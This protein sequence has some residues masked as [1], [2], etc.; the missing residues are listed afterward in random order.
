M[1]LGV[2]PHIFL[3]RLLLAFAVVYFL[4][5]P[6]APGYT[7]VLAGITRVALNASEALSGQSGRT[8]MYVREAADGKPAI[9]YQHGRFPQLESGI[10]A[11]WV[12]ANIVLLIPLMLAVP[13]ATYGQRGKRLALAILL[14]IL[15]QV[16]D[17]MVTVKAFY[18]SYPPTGYG[19]LTR[20]FYQFGDAFAQAFDT[21]LFPFVIW[22][23]I[24]FRQL[25]GQQQT[26]SSLPAAKPSPRPPR[27]KRKQ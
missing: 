17:V 27:N 4:W 18:A 16:L 10:A 7:G 15:L 20:R 3:A 13:A 12:Q 24:H 23:G 26:P 11:E 25:L 19:S 6:I 8:T 2:K 21:Q 1:R 9:Y 14:A 5:I 22:A